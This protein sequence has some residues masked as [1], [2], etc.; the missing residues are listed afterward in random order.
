MSGLVLELWAAPIAQGSWTWAFDDMM[1]FA[2]DGFVNL[3]TSTEQGGK[4]VID[5][6]AAGARTLP[7]RRPVC[8]GWLGR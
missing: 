1:L 5:G 3:E 2:Q 6:S 7:E 8:A 4:V